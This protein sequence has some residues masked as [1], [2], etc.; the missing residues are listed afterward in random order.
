M[1][2]NLDDADDD[3]P[4][5]LDVV[6]VLLDAH[7]ADD[8]LLSRLLLEVRADDVDGEDRLVVSFEIFCRLLGEEVGDA[9]DESAPAKDEDVLN[10]C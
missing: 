6:A 8:E 5:A 2:K 10:K 7:A 9:D 4:P 1:L 3:V